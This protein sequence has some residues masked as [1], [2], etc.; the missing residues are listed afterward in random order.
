MHF[1]GGQDP[2][3]EGGICILDPN[4]EIFFTSTLPYKDSQ[5]DHVRY[6][7]ILQ[8]INLQCSQ[9]SDTGDTRITMYIEK[10]Y[11]RPEDAGSEAYIKSL[12]NLAASVSRGLTNYAGATV[13]FEE[14]MADTTKALEEARKLYHARDRRDGRVGVLNYAKSAGMLFMGAML[15]WEIIEV[16]PRTWG[17]LLKKGHP[18]LLD[19]KE[20]SKWAVTRFDESLLM[21]GSPL[22]HS[23]RARKVHMGLLEAYLI[24]KYGRID[25]GLDILEGMDAS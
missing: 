2:G 1:I 10:I 6:A 17:E 5:I 18:G 15:G 14:A 20:K 3:R 25:Q 11:T 22:W 16:H 13:N 9:A 21:K 4:S 7:Q 24:A 12:E 23:T 19:S 8:E